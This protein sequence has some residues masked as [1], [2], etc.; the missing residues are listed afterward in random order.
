MIAPG[1]RGPQPYIFDLRCNAM[2]GFSLFSILKSQLE[3]M[4]TH[5]QRF[6]VPGLRML[7]SSGHASIL[8]IKFEDH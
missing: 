4:F 8:L 3:Q 1:V 2:L 5:S 6:M 7:Y